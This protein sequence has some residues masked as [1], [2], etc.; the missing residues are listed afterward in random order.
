M[1]VIALPT[2]A[3]VR[4]KKTTVTIAYLNDGAAEKRTMPGYVSLDGRWSIHR[5]TRG[6]EPTKKGW[7][8]THAPSGR[9]MPLEPSSFDAAKAFLGTLEQVPTPR[10]DRAIFGAI[11][12]DDQVKEEIAALRVAAE[13]SLAA[14]RA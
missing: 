9:A 3:G 10:L 13:S 6:G 14:Q 11:K 12:D 4:V 8:V 1:T 2:G 7:V 5:K